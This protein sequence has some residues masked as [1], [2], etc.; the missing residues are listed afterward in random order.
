[1]LKTYKIEIKPTEKQKQ[2]INQ[3]IGVCKYIYN[4]YITKNKEVYEQTK[5]FMS[6]NEFSKWLNNEFLPNNP[7]YNW[8]KDVSSK[9]VNKSICNAETS[10]KRFFKKQSKFPKYKNKSNTNTKM[11]LPKNNKTD[12]Y[13]ERHKVKIPTLGFVRLKEFGYIQIN[14]IV[15]SGTVSKVADKYFVSILVEEDVNYIQYNKIQEGI[16]VDLG[17][18]YFAICSNN[19][20]YKN[21]NKTNKIKKLEKKLKREQ[22][23]FSRKLENNKNKKK[24]GENSA[25]NSANIYKNKLR[26]QKLHMRLKNIRQEYVKFV[27]N[28][29]VKANNLPEFVSIEDLNV[30]G[31]IKN[32]HLSKAIQQQNFYYFRLFLIQQCKKYNV[33]V[34]IINRFYPSSKLCSCCGQIKKDLKLSDRIYKCDCGN[35]IDRDYQASLNIKECKIYKIAQ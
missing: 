6:A 27:V 28:S 2:K 19:K 32:R 9:A 4:F 18:K 30:K 34:R 3:T 1:M 35:I 22:R 8:I 7:S 21:I 16:G 33:E 29:L 17:I 14:S 20:N 26:L 5:K 31:M 15:K 11:Y 24:G 23:A 12:W 25:N 13:I 10:F